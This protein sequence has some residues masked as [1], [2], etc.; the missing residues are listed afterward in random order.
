MSEISDTKAAAYDPSLVGPKDT[1]DLKMTGEG[2]PGSHSAVFGL[3][4]D[5]KKDPNTIPQTSVPKPAHSKQT[6][7]GGGT[8][9]QDADDSSNTSSTA[10]AGGGVAKQMHDPRVA[11]KGHAGSEA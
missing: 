1:H 3:T 8:V 11:E 5:G 9:P 10:A 4:P 2:A 7:V 6:A